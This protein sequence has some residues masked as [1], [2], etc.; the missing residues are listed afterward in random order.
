MDDMRLQMRAIERA[1][2]LTGPTELAEAL[3]VWW[4]DVDRWRRGEA[5][6]PPALLDRATALIVQKYRALPS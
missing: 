6:M 4:S 1:I 3:G 2:A 5:R